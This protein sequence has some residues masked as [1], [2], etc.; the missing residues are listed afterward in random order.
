MKTATGKR[1]KR[2]WYD[3]LTL[4]LILLIIGGLA[5]YYIGYA[6]SARAERRARA[7]LEAAMAQCPIIPTNLD[8]FTGTTNFPAAGQYCLSCHNGIEPARPLGSPMMQEILA[9]GAQLGDP[10]GCVVCHGGTPSATED[11]NLAHKGVPRG[12]LLATFTPVPAAMQVNVN[13][14]GRCHK[15]HIY[16]SHRGLM[17]TDAGKVKTIAWSFGVGTENHNVRYADHDTD[18][19]DG[20]CPRAGT[21]TYQEYML[22]L[23]EMFPGQFPSSLDRMPAVRA[24][25]I[26]TNPEL[27]AFTYLRGCN[28]CHLANKGHRT[29]GHHR[30]MGCASCHSLYSNEGYYEGN[31]ASIPRDET[32][33]LMVHA[34]QSGRK[35]PIEVNGHTFSGVQVSTCAACHSAG[36]RIGHA[37][38]G[39]LALGTSTGRG[40]FDEQGR[41]QQPNASYV[42]KYMQPVTHH[43]IEVDG[44]MVTGLLCQDCHTTVGMHGDG[45]IA[46][47]GLAQVEIECSDCHGTPTHHPWELPLGWGDEFGRTLDPETPRGVALMPEAYTERFGTI[48]DREDGYLLTARGNPFGNVVRRGNRV[49]IHSATG[50]DFEVPQLKTLHDTGAWDRKS[51]AYIAMARVQR[52]M[53]NLECYACHA[54]WV[55]QYYGYKYVID[56]R[57][58]SIDWIASPELFGPDGTT[59]D[60]HG[61]HVKQPGAPT[62]GDYSHIRWEAPPLGINGEGRVSP[63]VGV[64]QTVSTIIGED[65]ETVI[66]NHVAQ[67]AQG[68]PAIELQPVQPHTISRE[69]RGCAECHGQAVA[70][71]Y[72]IDAGKYDARPN[73][74]RT[75]DVVDED[76]NI[77]SRFTQTQIHAIAQL[78]GDF[79]QLI[80]PEGVQVQT[81]DS[82]WPNSMPLTQDQRDRLD[83]NGACI[84]CH[85]DIPDGTIPNRMLTMVAKVA[86]LSFQTP[87]AHSD[88]LWQNNLMIA[89]IKALGV[90]FLI[91]IIPLV[92]LAIAKRRAIQRWWRRFRNLPAEGPKNE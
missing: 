40:P 75:A 92:I 29:R 17:A 42:F 87:Q 68:Y 62:Q 57:E 58:E 89:W 10:N 4:A 46:S 60:Y 56:Y 91:L 43:Q 78:H 90:L 32:G 19:P 54:T 64:I 15:D 73:I 84:A 67:T 31:D 38:Q 7:E 74:A 41:P 80:T 79:M 9:L 18:D 27:A 61:Q 52:H 34:M 77:V 48:H 39:F 13:T 35:S 21:Q 8:D 37:Y 81:I 30:G 24:K 53:D 88:L 2:R 69:T 36:R 20:P 45:N 63:L 1:R 28:A 85:A 76:G 65:G 14:C 26:E 83:R 50:R 25:E 6:L 16:N 3:Y 55:P 82:H 22:A 11:K 33:H 12:S 86:N 51:D 44:K 66:W 70:A 47:S 5:H 23:A 71:G 59:A 49:I 72:G